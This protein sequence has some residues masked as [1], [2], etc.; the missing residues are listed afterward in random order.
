[1]ITDL[2]GYWELR[3]IMKLVDSWDLERIYKEDNENNTNS[4]SIKIIYY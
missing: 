3:S 1:V 4:Y 2:F